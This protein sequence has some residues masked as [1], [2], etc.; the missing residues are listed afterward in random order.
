[1]HASSRRDLD[2]SEPCRQV[3]LYD[4][5]IRIAIRG[6]DEP[7]L[8]VPAWRCERPV[9]GDMGAGKDCT[10]GDKNGLDGSLHVSTTVLKQ[11]ERNAL[12]RVA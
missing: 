2:F 3:D 6:L 8:V 10:D 9:A 4:V 11:F 12:V 7:K 1:M 5:R